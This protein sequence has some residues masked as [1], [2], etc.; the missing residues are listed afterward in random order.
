MSAQTVAEVV[1]LYHAWASDPYDE[2]VSQL[3]HALQ[4]AALAR[5]ASASPELVA[6]A[7][8]HDVGHLLE[9]ADGLGFDT[10]DPIDH[11]HETRGAA[12]LADLF[13]PSVTRPIALHVEAKRYR[14]SVDSLYRSSLSDG[15]RTSLVRQGGA[16]SP[17]EAE[18]FLTLDGAPEAIALRAWDDYGKV[19]GLTIDPFDTYLDLLDSLA[20]PA[21]TR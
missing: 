8:L 14:V 3:D 6:A 18:A 5:T 12:F 21:A 20:R 10:A 19:E 1:A 13:P 4:T 7:L 2:S 15:S 9:L 11:A 17:R 16:H